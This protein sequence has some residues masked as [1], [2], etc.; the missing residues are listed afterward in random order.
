MF[1]FFMMLIWFASLILH[2][3]VQCGRLPHLDLCKLFSCCRNSDT[4]EY[5]TSIM[6]REKLPIVLIQDGR[7]RNQVF[8]NRR[9]GLLKKCEELSKLCGIEVCLISSPPESFKKQCLKTETYPEDADKVKRIVKEYRVLA[10]E[11]GNNAKN[12]VTLADMLRD[13]EAKL[14]QELALLRLPPSHSLEEGGLHSMTESSLRSMSA[15]LDR[16]LASIGAAIAQRRQE[17]AAAIAEPSS[18]S[19]YYID[20]NYFEVEQSSNGS[21]VAWKGFIAE[22]LSTY[23]IDDN[24]FKVE[25]SSAG[26]G[27]DWKTA[28]A[29]PSNYVGDGDMVGQSNGMVWSTTMECLMPGNQAQ[30]LDVSYK[31]SEFAVYDMKSYSELLHRP[32]SPSGFTI[33][34]A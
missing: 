20:N 5:V 18:S 31:G 14:E 23:Y 13:K 30:P 22:P 16:K 19:C 26:W 15:Q 25:Q 1:L 27:M 21:G 6:G 34:R 4:G 32:P 24:Y 10:G 11:G 33:E 3:L 12:Q 7:K 28:I 9:K 8:R 17:A 29:E 2:I